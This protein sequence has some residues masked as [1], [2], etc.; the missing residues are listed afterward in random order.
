MELFNEFPGSLRYVHLFNDGFIRRIFFLFG[1]RNKVPEID[2]EISCRQRFVGIQLHGRST[3]SENRNPEKRWFEG[4]FGT[5]SQ[6]ECSCF[7][8]TVFKNDSCVECKIGTVSSSSL[9]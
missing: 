2:A 7:F 5:E 8:G 1:V 9:D 4:N 6:E 3:L